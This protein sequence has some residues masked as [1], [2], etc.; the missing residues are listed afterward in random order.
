MFPGIAADEVKQ[1]VHATYNGSGERFCSKWMARNKVTS[2]PDY[3]RNLLNEVRKMGDLDLKDQELVRKIKSAG[4]S[5][6]HAIRSR[7][8]FV[9]NEAHEARNRDKAL[10][11]FDAAGGSSLVSLEH[12]GTPRLMTGDIDLVAVA[13]SVGVAVVLKPYRGKSELIDAL[14]AMDPDV[15]AHLWDEVEADWFENLNLQERREDAYNVVRYYLQQP[16]KDDR[17]CPIAFAQALQYWE[18]DTAVGRKMI[19]EIF[20]SVPASKTSL[21]VWRYSWKWEQKVAKVQVGYLTDRGVDLVRH[22]LGPGNHQQ[23][24]MKTMFHSAADHMV[25]TMLY[26]PSIVNRFNTSAELILFE[27]GMALHRDSKD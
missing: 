5:G 13:A 17:S 1:L 23:C 26:K 22:L 11:A 15:P 27:G 12:D 9:K 19:V 16:K 7:A 3:H 2:L 6:E 10:A 14:K 24:E 4:I 18:V 25:S 20:A 8:I 21:F